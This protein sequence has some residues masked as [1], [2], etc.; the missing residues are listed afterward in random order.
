MHQDGDSD[1]LERAGSKGDPGPACTT[2]ESAYD[3][4]VDHGFTG[5]LEDWLASLQGPRG[6]PGPKGDP[7][8]QGPAGQACTLDDNGNGTV[9]LTCGDTNAVL[10]K[11]GSAEPAPTVSASA[12]SNAVEGDPLVFDV[13]LS[14]TWTQPVTVNY[15]TSDGTATAP[16]DYQEPVRHRDDLTRTDRHHRRR[17]H[18]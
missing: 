16:E 7:G 12:P 15:A 17:R 1:H 2:G 8:A 13:T 10:P 3:L 5:P 6:D 4:A 11:A 9:T 14:H 18:R